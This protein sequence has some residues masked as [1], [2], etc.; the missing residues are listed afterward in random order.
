MK[1]TKY[2]LCRVMTALAAVA[3]CFSM[4]AC[5]GGDSDD[6][7]LD[8]GDTPGN[9][10]SRKGVHRLEIDFSRDYTP[11]KDRGMY[12]FAFKTLTDETDIFDY[13]G[14]LMP[15]RRA[16]GI[17]VSKTESCLYYTKDDCISFGVTM[18]IARSVGDDPLEITIRGYINDKQT[19]ER[20]YTIPEG[21]LSTIYFNTISDGSDIFRQDDLYD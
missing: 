19:K 11:K 5:G 18:Y 3:M 15:T 20:S 8:G 9:R 7:T 12:F 6:D 2:F 4:S 13:N 14:N 21:K 16:Q 17:E 1:R 10:S